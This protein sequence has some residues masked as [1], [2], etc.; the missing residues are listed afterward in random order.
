MVVIASVI[1]LFSS[2]ISKFPFKIHLLQSMREILVDK[3]RNVRLRAKLKGH[4]SNT[5]L[6]KEMS[7]GRSPLTWRNPTQSPTL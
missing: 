5:V 2:F 7:H 3:N 1:D 6:T 4:K